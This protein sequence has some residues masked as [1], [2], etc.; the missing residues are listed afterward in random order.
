ME[1]EQGGRWWWVERGDGMRE[2]GRRGE[3]ATPS[4]PP[5]HKY[6]RGIA[7]LSQNSHEQNVHQASTGTDTRL[8]RKEGRR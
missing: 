7:R 5:S 4:A 1:E 3:E 8:Q 6:G 2:G